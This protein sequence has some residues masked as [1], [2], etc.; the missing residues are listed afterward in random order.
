MT[1]VLSLN[2][3]VSSSFLTSSGPEDDNAS[4]VAAKF[5]REK[6]KRTCKAGNH[7]VTLDV[8]VL[9]DGMRRYKELSEHFIGELT[10]GRC[11]RCNDA[12]ASRYDYDCWVLMVRN[13][14]Q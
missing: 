11:G 4:D 7:M 10:T 3:E 12:E 2:N 9:T 8:S 6:M 13:G 14:C 5:S 1:F